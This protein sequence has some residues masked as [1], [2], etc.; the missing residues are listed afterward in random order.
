[1]LYFCQENPNISF[2]PTKRANI[3]DAN[4]C[5]SSVL[6]F[7]Y[8]RIL[9]NGRRGKKPGENEQYLHGWVTRMMHRIPY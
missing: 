5:Q 3:S 4:C 8:F 2:L 7:Y 9:W 6:S 1:M